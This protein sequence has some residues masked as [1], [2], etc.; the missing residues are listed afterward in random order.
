MGQLAQLPHHLGP[1]RRIVQQLVGQLSIKPIG[2][3][4]PHRIAPVMGPLHIVQIR[5]LERN[6]PLGR[7]NGPPAG[8]NHIDMRIPSLLHQLCQIV[9][10]PKHVPHQIKRPL[11]PHRLVGLHQLNP[12]L[13]ESTLHYRHLHLPSL[14]QPDGLHPLPFLLFRL[15]LLSLPRCLL[16]SRLFRSH[17]LLP[18]R[19]VFRSR[20]LF[21]RFLPCL[22]FLLLRCLSRISL[23]SLLQS[24]PSPSRLNSRFP[25]GNLSPW[26]HRTRLDHRPSFHCLRLY[27]T[28]TSAASTRSLA[29]STSPGSP[30]H[31]LGQ[32]SQNRTTQENI[33]AHKN[34]FQ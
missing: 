12:R 9:L 29:P 16:G 8:R 26:L 5:C 33:F 23:L 6:I 4:S 17:L 3:K 10:R 28:D 32:T 2:N 18:L 31:R 14:G 24:V 1:P 34:S 27:R 20:R 13:P 15:G 19:L 11:H 25:P 30:H 7:R 21:G 22:R